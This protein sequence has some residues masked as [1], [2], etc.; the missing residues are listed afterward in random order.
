MKHFQKVCFLEEIKNRTKY[1]FI[2]QRNDAIKN[3][4]LH[5]INNTQNS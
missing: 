3:N 2:N 1:Y 4:T 5:F